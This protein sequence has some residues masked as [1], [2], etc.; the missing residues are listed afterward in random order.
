MAEKLGPLFDESNLIFQN[1]KVHICI[2][3]CNKAYPCKHTVITSILQKQQVVRQDTHNM[4]GLE[5]C[6]HL[7]Q[8]N[9]SD[10]HFSAYAKKVP[11]LVVGTL[12]IYIDETKTLV[13]DRIIPNYYT[14]VDN[15]LHNLDHKGLVEYLKNKN[16]PFDEPQIRSISKR[17]KI[18]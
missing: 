18:S 13:N 10:V 11:V 1:D 15:G 12:E 17:Y 14:I 9:F 8:W 3:P 4:F 16:L 7:A 5:I 6:N 2:S